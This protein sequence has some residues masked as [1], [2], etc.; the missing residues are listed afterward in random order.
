MLPHNTVE[1]VTKFVPV[2]VSVKA[3]P[4]ATAVLGAS[5]VIVGPTTVKVDAE[6]VAP[7]GLCTVRLSLPMLP[8]RVGDIVAVMDV[9]VP[10]VTASAVVPE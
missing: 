4:A 3:A 6:D 1:L 8:T 9:E 10:A 5:V 2:T 7:P